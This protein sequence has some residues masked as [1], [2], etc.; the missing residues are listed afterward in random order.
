MLWSSAP[1][2]GADDWIVLAAFSLLPLAAA[3]TYVLGLSRIGASMTSV[4]ASFSI[5]LTILFQLALL[6]FGI[7]AILP[8]NVVLAI[9]GGTLGVLGIFLIHQK[10]N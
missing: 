3:L 7:D 10:R 1:S 2:I 4:I 5:L 6:R 9:A 8:S